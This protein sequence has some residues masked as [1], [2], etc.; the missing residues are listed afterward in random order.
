MWSFTSPGCSERVTLVAGQ[1][2]TV[3]RPKGDEFCPT[4][5]LLDYNSV[6]RGAH[7]TV[8]A[9]LDGSG[10]PLLEVADSSTHGVSL[11][12][13]SSI[14]RN[15]A[16]LFYPQT[17][18]IRDS[19]RKV[20]KKSP[21][22]TL[23]HGDLVIFGLDAEQLAKTAANVESR[24]SPTFTVQFTPLAVLPSKLE[25]SVKKSVAET[26]AR[27]GARTLDDTEAAVTHLVCGE[28]AITVR[29]SAPS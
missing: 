2:F 8:T 7:A 18:V 3:G 21:P 12:G 16:M 15:Y 1:S 20:L 19:A 25:R 27:I 28:L 10:F 24:P 9:R 11:F 23:Q 29:P 17:I 22:A 5:V 26:A 14:P 4:L 6:S 13:G